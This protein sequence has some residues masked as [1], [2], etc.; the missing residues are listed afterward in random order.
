[1]IDLH[2]L[3][4]H[5]FRFISI[6][7]IRLVIRGPCAGPQVAGPRGLKHDYGQYPKSRQVFQNFSVSTSYKNFNICG[8]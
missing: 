6:H 4:S 8:K 5:S 7:P 3:M 1:V 2:F